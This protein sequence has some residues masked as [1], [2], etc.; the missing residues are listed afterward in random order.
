MVVIGIVLC[1]LLAAILVS[2][3]VIWGT[4]D[5]ERSAHN[6]TVEEHLHDM[7]QTLEGIEKEIQIRPYYNGEGVTYPYPREVMDH[8]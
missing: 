1:V 5:D 8:D 3:W 6:R 7:F 2:L 4:Y